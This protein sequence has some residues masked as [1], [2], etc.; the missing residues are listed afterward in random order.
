MSKITLKNNHF[1]YQYTNKLPI[2]LSNDDIFLWTKTVA[3]GL[4][5]IKKSD[6]SKSNF[7]WF[8]WSPEDDTLRWG[9]LVTDW[10]FSFNFKLSVICNR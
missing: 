1:T 5:N 9:E 7:T 3:R 2:L 10:M 6:T 4:P 8:D